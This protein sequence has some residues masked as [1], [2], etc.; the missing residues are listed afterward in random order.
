M[1]GGFGTYGCGTA[2][3]GTGVLVVFAASFC[4]LDD[5]TEDAIAVGNDGNDEEALGGPNMSNAV[6]MFA[7]DADDDSV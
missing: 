5:S 4:P 1:D 7:L 6:D 3:A 2:G